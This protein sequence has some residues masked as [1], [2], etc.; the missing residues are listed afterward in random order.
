MC[1]MF[2][3]LGSWTLSSVYGGPVAVFYG[4]FTLGLSLDSRV[5]VRGALSSV[6]CGVVLLSLSMDVLVFS[7]SFV[8]SLTTLWL[9]SSPVLSCV[10]SFVCF[11]LSRLVL[12]VYACPPPPFLLSVWWPLSVMGLIVGAWF[13]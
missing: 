1:S 11:F 13:V 4:V 5:N 2:C 8:A 6:R 7:D 9:V 12:M 3:V 10:G